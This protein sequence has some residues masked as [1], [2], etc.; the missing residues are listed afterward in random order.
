MPRVSSRPGWQMAWRLAFWGQCVVVTVLMLW[1]RPPAV[2]DLTGWDKLN[3][4]LAF[5]GP[6]LAG[7]LARPRRGMATGALLLTAL[8][9]WGGALELLQSALPPRQGDWADL[10]ADA[11]GLAIGALCYRTLPRGLKPSSA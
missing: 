11:V 6:A 2:T 10:L 8:L 1:P 5:A 3:H 7:L 9:A 4:A